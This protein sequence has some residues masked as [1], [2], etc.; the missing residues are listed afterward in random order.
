MKDIK[1]FIFGTLCLASIPL[2]QAAESLEDRLKLLERKIEIQ[3]ETQE[4]QKQTGVTVVA[5]KDGFSIKSNDNQYQLKLRGLIQFDT[6]SWF[7]DKAFPQNSGFLVRRVRPIIE[8]SFAKY[9]EYKFVPDLGAGAVAVQ[10]AY[11]DFKLLPEFV[12]R[13]G[14]YI[15]PVG[16]ERLQSSATTFFTEN[17]L[18]TNLVP[19]RDVGYGFYGNLWE[20]LFSYDLGLFNGVA[21]G[22]SGDTDVDDNKDLAVRVFTH[23]FQNFEFE[24]LQGLGLG[25][26]F[27][28][29]DQFGTATNTSVAAYRTPGQ[30]S[31][32]TYAAGTVA[33]GQHQR[34]S[35]QFFWGWGSTGLLGEWV[36]SSQAVKTVANTATLTHQSWQLSVAHA[37]TGEIESTK[38][39]KPFKDFSPEN[40]TWG[41]FE[42]VT[43]ISELSIDPNTFPNFASATASAQKANSTALGLNWYLNRNVKWVFDYEDTVFTGGAA[44]GNRENEQIFFT[45]FQLTY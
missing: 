32:F 45:R 23:P 2:L 5:G 16:I 20:G 25:Y 8:G 21:D 30:Q 37:L 10:D 11:V 17:A 33:N 18:P 24:F 13:Y 9:F 31:F 34:T 41:A 12:F 15:P 27:I 26:A 28:S 35:P 29:G 14:K 7:N 4:G 3:E 38:G 43:R 42:L 22:S 36:Q 44:S 6:R 19:N 39:L 1:L 40:G